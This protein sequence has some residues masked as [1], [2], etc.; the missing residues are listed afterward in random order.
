[1]TEYERNIIED[2]CARLRHICKAYKDVDLT[3]CTIV[4]GDLP[5]THISNVPYLP[6]LTISEYHLANCDNYKAC[7]DFEDGFKE[8]EINETTD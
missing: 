8:E 1:M 7:R 5:Y 2:L 4:G 6:C 3:K